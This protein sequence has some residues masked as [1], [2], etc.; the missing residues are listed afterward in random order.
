MIKDKSIKKIVKKLRVLD[1]GSLLEFVDYWDGDL[2]AIGFKRNDK[3]VYVSTCNY[4]KE[5]PLR[6]DVDLE[7]LDP[8][9]IDEIDVIQELRGIGDQELFD[10]IKA[11]LLA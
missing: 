4:L 6:Y 9:R 7:I 1:S 5:K 11:F 8:N 10:L 2:C 3:L